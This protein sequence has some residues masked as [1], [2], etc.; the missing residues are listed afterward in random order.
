MSPTCAL[1]AAGHA[2][3]ARRPRAEQGRRVTGDITLAVADVD[4]VYVGL[5]VLLASVGDARAAREAR[6]GDLPLRDRRRPLTRCRRSPASTARRSSRRRVVARSS[7]SRRAR[8]EPTQEA[9]L[10]HARV[11]EALLA[12]ADAVL[13]VRFGRA[14]RRDRGARGARCAP[15]A[16]TSSSACDV[17]AAA[18]RSACASSR[19]RERGLKRSRGG[20]STCSAGCDDEQPARAGAAPRAA[21]P[22]SRR[23]PRGA[24]VGAATSSS[25]RTS[26][27]REDVATLSRRGRASSQA[28]NPSCR[29]PAPGR[30]RRTASRAEARRERAR[31]VD[32]VLAGSGDLDRSPASW[33]SV[34]DAFPRRINADPEKVERGLAQLVL[35][36][37][38]LLRQLME[39]QALRRMEGGTLTD[40]Q[41]ERLGETFMKLEQRMDELKAR[42]RPRGPGPE[43]RSRAARKPALNLHENERVGDTRRSP[44]ERRP[45]MAS[46]KDVEQ[47]ADDL[48]SLVDNLRRRSATTR[49]STSSFGSRTRS[50]STP[51]RQPERSA[52]STKR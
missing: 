46:L 52:P 34:Q 17:C 2:G 3:R 27:A 51:T 15:T 50:A 30:G 9:V 45:P 8:V 43:P 32:K 1:A 24:S 21:R 42:V 16:P 37:V 29:S 31:A 13:P 20:A 4:L 14:L 48:A 47:V 25:A 49:A 44:R 39:R 7:A 10:A 12:A 40:E 18:S 36:L 28:A 26:S 19:R 11:V 33:S 35:T 22:R 5:R 41:I 38:E 23:R 6:C